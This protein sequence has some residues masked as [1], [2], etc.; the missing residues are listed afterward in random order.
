MT[1]IKDKKTYEEFEKFVLEFRNSVIDWMIE[2]P[3]GVDNFQRFV[4]EMMSKYDNKDKKLDSIKN[5]KKE[6]NSISGDF[7]NILIENAFE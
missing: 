3:V 7:H 2:D 6:N 5:K 4:K 1:K